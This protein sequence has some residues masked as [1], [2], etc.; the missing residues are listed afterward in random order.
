M[1]GGT[2]KSRCLKRGL[3]HENGEQSPSHWG[4]SQH[5]HHRAPYG[6]GKNLDTDFKSHG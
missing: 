6:C 2:K 3:V 1:H 5:S 4:G